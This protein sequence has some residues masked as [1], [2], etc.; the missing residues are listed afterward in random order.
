MN[1]KRYILLLAAGL[2]I[3]LTPFL[4]SRIANSAIA[5]TSTATAS[6]GSIAEITQG[7]VRLKRSQWSSYRSVPIG[8]AINDGDLIWPEANTTATVACRDGSTR[9]VPSGQVSGALSLCPSTQ[10]QPSPRSSSTF[11]DWLFNSDRSQ[12][13]GGGTR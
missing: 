12:P 13:S 1:I 10:R 6:L 2:G 7:E 4:A 9:R 5:Q 8:T 11:L 3:A